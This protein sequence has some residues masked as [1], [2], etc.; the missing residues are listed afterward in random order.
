ME[1]QIKKTEMGR[2]QRLKFMKFLFSLLTEASET[3][4]FPLK[5]TQSEKTGDLNRMTPLD[6]HR[7]NIALIFRHKSH[8]YIVKFIFEKAFTPQHQEKYIKNEFSR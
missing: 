5:H 3:S 7:S 1:F 8:N 4:Q 6:L 2:D